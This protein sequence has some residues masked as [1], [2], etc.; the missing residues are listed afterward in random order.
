ME[1][2]KIIRKRKNKNLETPAEM[3]AIEGKPNTP[4]MIAITKKINAHV[5]IFTPFN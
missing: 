1:R 2:R 3:A 5:N 4:L